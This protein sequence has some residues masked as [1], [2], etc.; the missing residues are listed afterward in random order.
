M[1]DALA[2]IERLRNEAEECRLISK[3]ATSNAKRESF[4]RLAEATDKQA[5]ELEA[6]VA[7]GDLPE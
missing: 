1:K 6:V 3:L 7:S 4:A 2:W 5:N